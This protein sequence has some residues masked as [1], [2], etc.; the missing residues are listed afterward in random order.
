MPAGNISLSCLV[1][2]S[3]LGEVIVSKIPELIYRVPTLS[4][5]CSIPARFHRRDLR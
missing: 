2:F 5:H 1:E 4:R 3:T